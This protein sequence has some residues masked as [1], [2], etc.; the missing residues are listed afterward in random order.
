MLSELLAQ[1]KRHVEFNDGYEADFRKGGSG[2]FI[3]YNQL[4]NK[5]PVKKGDIAIL[6]QDEQKFIQSH[7]GLK[8]P[9]AETEKQTD[10]SYGEL[11]EESEDNPAEDNEESTEDSK[12]ESAPAK[13]SAP[14]KQETDKERPAEQ[15]TTTHPNKTNATSTTARTAAPTTVTPDNTEL[16]VINQGTVINGDYQSKV[17]IAVH[18][19]LKG[20]IDSKMKITASETSEIRGNINA[21]NGCSLSG[22]IHG[23]V[24]IE[25][26]AKLKGTTIGNFRSD[27]DIDMEGAK[28]RG[29]VE[30]ERITLDSE[31]IIIGN[32]KTKDIVINGSVQGNVTAENLAK[33]ESSA[34]VVGD[35]HAEK[36]IIEEGAMFRGKI[37]QTP[38]NANIEARFESLLNMDDSGNKKKKVSDLKDTETTEVEKAEDEF[39]I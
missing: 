22:V 38:G 33:L 24:N 12:E 37:E 31:S 7:E 39:G 9:V 25:G 13:E 26:S 20:N 30:G 18:G 16:D 34:A 28:I 11:F 4:Q 32:V 5:E 6:P 27:S 19:T 35:I 29:D 8:D 21:L 14:E 2:N 3:F 17:N 23:D 1:G 15:T 10:E 36:V